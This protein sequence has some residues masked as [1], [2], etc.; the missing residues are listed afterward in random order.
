MGMEFSSL[1]QFKNDVL[2]HNVLNGR[3]VRFS[4]NDGNRCRVV[5]IGKKP[6]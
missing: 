1:R 5:C 6:M 2:E 3:E 4:K